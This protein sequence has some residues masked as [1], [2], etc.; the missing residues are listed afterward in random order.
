MDSFCD[1]MKS[2]H[3]GEYTSADSHGIM[4]YMSY[5]SAHEKAGKLIR[6]YPYRCSHELYPRPW[7]CYAMEGD[8]SF[9][10]TKDMIID[11]SLLLLSLIYASS[12][13]KHAAFMDL[14]YIYTL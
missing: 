11:I 10:K 3:C 7:R 12:K 13:R 5:T 8:D 14:L 1:T 6:L 2:N 9:S 4:S